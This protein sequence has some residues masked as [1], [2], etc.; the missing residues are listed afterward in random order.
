MKPS[1][2]ATAL[3]GLTLALGIPVAG[4]A[5]QNP[6]KAIESSEMHHN[7]HR[8]EAQELPATEPGQGAFAAIAEIVAALE[9]DPAT[10]WSKV[11]IAALRAHLQDMNRVVLEANAT[12][13]ALADGMRF[14]ITGTGAGIGAIQRM[15]LAH[16]AVMNGVNGWQMS[17]RQIDKGAQLDVLVPPRDNAKLAALG[18]FGLLAMGM[19]HPAHHWALATGQNPHQ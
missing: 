18:F 19:H 12:R 2:R 5:Q 11:D 1:K 10:D 17:A 6:P 8:S 13:T 9:A 15:V 14:T 16:A 7:M 4:A 3:A